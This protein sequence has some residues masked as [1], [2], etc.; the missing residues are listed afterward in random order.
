MSKNEPTFFQWKNRRISLYADCV[1]MQ[2][3]RGSYDLSLGKY[4]I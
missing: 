4:L 1:L 3:L 2:Q